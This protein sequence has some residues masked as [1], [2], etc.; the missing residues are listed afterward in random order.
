MDIDAQY[1]S[2]ILFN[3]GDLYNITT[4][5]FKSGTFY[6]ASHITVPKCHKVFIFNQLNK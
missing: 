3:K 6:I 4:G 1:G 5:T 2:M